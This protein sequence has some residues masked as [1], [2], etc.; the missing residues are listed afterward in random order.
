MKGGNG[1]AEAMADSVKV[2]SKLREKT[3][4]SNTKDNDIN[5]TPAT[6]AT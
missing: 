4:L 3:R 5:S 6:E 2:V 1:A